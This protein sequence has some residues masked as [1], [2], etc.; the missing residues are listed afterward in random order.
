[1]NIQLEDLTFYYDKKKVLHDIN[2]QIPEGRLTLVCGVTGSSKSTLL[3]IIAGLDKPAS[4][5]IS[6][7]KHEAES[8]VSMVFQ[9]PETQ[10][11]A[12]SAYKDIEYGLEQREVPKFH[13]TEL[14]HQALD[15]VGLP[16]EQFSER[17]PFLLSGGE[18]RKLC[19]AG[20]IAATPE[21]LILDEPTAGLDPQA[22]RSLLETVQEL[23]TSGLTIVIG[24]HDLDSFFPI[25]DEVVVMSRGYVHDQ[26]PVA[27]L[28]AQPDRL[29]TAGLEAPAYVRMGRKLHVL[30]RLPLIPDSPEGLLQLL[31]T[32]SYLIPA[33][34]ALQAESKGSGEL[35]NFAV[36]EDSNEREEENPSSSPVSARKAR[37][38]GL[39]PRVK[40]LGMVL[41]TLVI[42]GMDSPAPLLLTTGLIVVLIGSADIS[43]KRT[44]AFFR[45]FL[46]MFL[47]LWMVSSVSMHH[48]D[49]QLGPL[50]ISYSGM[51]Q[52]G[53]SILRFVL[54]IA[55][56]FLFTETTT[57]APLREALEWAIAPLKKLGIHTRN[58]SLAV[59]IT[60]QFVPWILRKISQLQLALRSR[61]SRKNRLKRWTPR[62]MALMIVPLLILVIGMGDELA[63]SI[64]SRGYDP[65]KE[66]T[67]WFVLTWDRKDTLVL[68]FVIITAAGLWLI[69]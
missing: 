39:D 8:A 25:A 6:Y 2:L 38:Q 64:E 9:M 45:P 57:G 19:I 1:M 48:A 17:S 46:V 30:G 13:R 21:L 59:S 32:Q 14:V 50:G 4:G 10:L 68:A 15:T 26:G 49:W 36:S 5:S 53:F 24:T 34:N 44:V 18:K 55:L 56:G 51:I 47:F 40:W 54:M 28:I 20:A 66:R 29:S 33:G 35:L 61:G 69:S 65:S 22:V 37:W 52:G 12:S 41:W 16:H 3:R 43:W 58:W 27:T 63:T 31:S 60:L 23:R 7:S 67:P 62:Q 11:F 42:L